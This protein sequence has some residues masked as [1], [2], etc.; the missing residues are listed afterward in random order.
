MAGPWEKFQSAGGDES[1]P[2][3]KFGAG[4]A[5][6]GTDLPPLDQNTEG[7]IKFKTGR[8][9]TPSSFVDSLSGAPVRAGLDAL[10]QKKGISGAFSA[11]KNAFGQDP[12]TAPSSVDVVYDSGVRNPYAGAALSTA[13]DL[14]DQL[15]VF[16]GAGMA[17]KGLAR[18]GEK[19]GGL[20][21]DVAEKR[22]FK[23]LGP[24]KKFEDM[25]S[26]KGLVNDIGRQALDEGVVTPL[27]SKQK[28]LSRVEN[29]QAQKE[30]DLS[31]VLKDV[32]E[33]K[34]LAP[35]QAAALDLEGTRFNPQ[36]A[37]EELKNKLAD[38]KDEIPP[39]I[40]QP[41]MDQYDQ[42]LSKGPMDAD[43]AQRFKLQMQD[44]IKDP[45][46][47]KANPQASQ[48]GLLDIRRAIKSGIENDSN[49]YYQALGEDPGK[50]KDINRGLGNLYEMEDILKDRVSRNAANRTISPSDYFTGLLGEHAATAAGGKAAGPLGL[51][52]VLAHK[53]A[54]EKGSQITATGADALSKL[55]SNPESLEAIS[56]QAPILTTGSATGLLKDHAVQPLAAERDK[57]KRGF[58][59][60]Q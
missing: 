40:L 14:G 44:F 15:P 2:W 25:A 32:S 19:L 8:G 10:A 52:A 33:R 50:V 35:E 13:L 53:F 20:L 54:R 24:V 4:D 43:Q 17:A 31:G 26:A 58:L 9:I 38:E 1:G 23:A 45:S 48:Q 39:E 37:A 41:R 60:A 7:L 57:K 51:A 42:W 47:W 27:A 11:A 12:E 6:T 30:A 28:M 21:G 5:R 46:Y 55:L 18:G 29:L 56:Q 34:G 59:T 16:E 22:A 36:V 3:Q 49:A